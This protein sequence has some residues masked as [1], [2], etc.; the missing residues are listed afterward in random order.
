MSDTAVNV[1][2]SRDVLLD[3]EH[4]SMH[5]NVRSRYKK[6]TVKAVD[7]V[8]FQV[9]RSETFGLVG[10]SGCGKTPTGRTFL[11]LYNPTA[12]SI[13]LAGREISGK[14]TQELRN[15]LTSNITCIFQDPIDSLNPRMTVSEIIGEGL[16]VR[17]VSDKKEIENRVYQVLEKVGLTREHANRY[18]HE[19]SGGQ[20]QRI[21][22]LLTP[23]CIYKQISVLVERYLRRVTDGKLCRHPA[24]RQKELMA[25]PVQVVPL[26]HQGID[27]IRFYL[28]DPHPLYQIPGGFMAEKDQVRV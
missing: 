4:L 14:M 9:Y 21:G 10:E 13:K 5:F 23:V 7:D 27:L 20:R 12:G 26:L 15:Y 11:R 1:A 2:D 24:V 18:P 3:V 6:S 22:I 25:D 19:F 16:K 28:A 17:G 8:S